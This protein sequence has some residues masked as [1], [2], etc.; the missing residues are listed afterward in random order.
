MSGNFVRMLKPRAIA[1]PTG[2]PAKAIIL[3]NAPLIIE[4]NAP[5]NIFPIPPMMLFRPFE[6][7][8]KLEVIF[9]KKP[10]V[11]KGGGE[12]GIAGGGGGMVAGA[13]G[14]S[15]RT[16]GVGISGGVGVGVVGFFPDNNDAL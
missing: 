10:G 7:L 5:P 12:V 3:P 8:A 4:P 14:I 6:I 13:N 16:G 15:G 9:F 11:G 1:S 2:P